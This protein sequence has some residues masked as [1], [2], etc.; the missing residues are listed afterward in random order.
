M[1][2]SAFAFAEFS[3]GMLWGRISDKWGR[4]PVLI[5]GLAGTLV[6]MLVFGFAT[7][8]PVALLARALGGGLNGN[9]G[10]IQTTVAEL[11]TEK[12]HQP[13]A[14]SI[15]PFIWC[16]GYGFNGLCGSWDG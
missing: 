1:V 4:K 3:T 15:M 11:V 14:F 10:V 16:L 8:F 2:T 7:S 12:E 9:I 13:K 6:S 5:M